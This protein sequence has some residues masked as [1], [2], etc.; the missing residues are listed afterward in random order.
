[1]HD[2]LIIYI[3]NQLTVKLSEEEISLIKSVFK[4]K[5][6]RKH[7]YLLQAGDVCKLAGFLLKGAMKLYTVD[8]TGKESILDLFLE[9][10][11]V[12]DKESFQ[13]ASPSPYYIDA[14]EETEMLLVSKTDY[15][16]YLQPQRFMGE[17]IGSLMEKRALQLYKQVYAAKT[18]TAEQRLIDLEGKHPEFFQRFPQR[19]IASYLGM[20]KETLSRIRANFLKK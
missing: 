14:C 17:F 20:T 8:D 1:M 7:Q 3:N 11:W 4:Y 15:D 18:L 10:W 9:N 6:L 13:T 2:N 5:K 19:I 16:K 12:G